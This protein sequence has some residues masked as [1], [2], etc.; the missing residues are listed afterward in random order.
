MVMPSSARI[1]STRDNVAA[2]ASI[3]AERL[4]HA[5]LIEVISLPLIAASA[6]TGPELSSQPGGALSR[7]PPAAILALQILFGSQMTKLSAFGIFTLGKVW[8]FIS[9]FSPMILLSDRM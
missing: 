3:K 7:A 2:A 6:F 9:S 4:V 1:E 5:A 8:A